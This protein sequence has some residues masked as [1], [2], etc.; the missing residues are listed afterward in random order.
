[1]TAKLPSCYLCG[2]DGIEVHHV[3]ENVPGIYIDPVKNF[4][5]K[6]FVC[7]G[8]DCVRKGMFVSDQA[9]AEN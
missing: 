5:F 4:T 1:M 2:E 6:R 8:E 7:A 3:D 9:C